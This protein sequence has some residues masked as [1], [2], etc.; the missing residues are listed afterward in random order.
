MT[1]CGPCS[2]LPAA[3]CGGEG[4]GL[5]PAPGASQPAPASRLFH[6]RDTLPTC[7]LG[8]QG[9]CRGPRHTGAGLWPGVRKQGEGVAG[10]ASWPRIR[11]R[12]QLR[13]QSWGAGRG[14]PTS[15]W[16]PPPVSFRTTAPGGHALVAS[17]WLIQPKVLGQKNSPSVT[18]WHPALGTV[19]IQTHPSC[20]DLPLHPET[21]L[22]G[23]CSPPCPHPVPRTQ[24][25]DP[26]GQASGH[27]GQQEAWPAAVPTHRDPGQPT[28]MDR[29]PASIPRPTA[30]V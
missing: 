8:V 10:E 23:S 13:A 5:I 21:P 12:C 4:A 29:I 27:I 18:A 25:K 16:P 19:H 17:Q 20:A 2:D 6:P 1:G 14:G 24:H 9:D 30:P 11:R 15:A 26:G 7:G 28:E 22:S 3:R